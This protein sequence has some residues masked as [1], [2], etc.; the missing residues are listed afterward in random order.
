MELQKG[1]VQYF[2]PFV[3]LKLKQ[4]LQIQSIET[5][6]WYSKYQSYSFNTN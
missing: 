1:V 2:N 5:Y 6:S 3:S 4:E